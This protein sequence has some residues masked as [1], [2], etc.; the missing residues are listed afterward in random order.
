MIES[1]GNVQGDDRDANHINQQYLWR[2]L[3][4]PDNNWKEDLS[5]ELTADEAAYLKERIIWS[6]PNSLWAFTLKHCAEEARTF[7]SI[8]DFLSVT[9]LPNDLKDIVQ[10][11]T[12]F[13]KIMQGALIRYNLLIQASR[14]NGRTKELESS[15]KEYCKMIK[16]FDWNS[17]ST[18]KL[19]KYCPFTPTSTKLFVEK[20]ISIAQST[21]INLNSTDTLIKDREVRLKG[22][23][24][25]RLQDKAVAQKQETF[26]G[27]TVYENGAV[28][29]L[30]YRWNN[31]RTFLNDI[32]D[33]L[34]N[35]VT[36]K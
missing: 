20:W 19:W 1:D 36:T 14:E 13:N 7:F 33:G 6:N 34:A 35:N 26:T 25:A 2:S 5:I 11:A 8:E 15:W 4:K 12:D 29:Y 3:P 17:W 32:Q 22:M 24:R 18:E 9:N 30:T 23:R 21:T 28:S 16:V 27:L 31:V 10:L